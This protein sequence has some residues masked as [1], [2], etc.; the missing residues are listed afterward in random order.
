MNYSKILFLVLLLI[1]NEF[2]ITPENLEIYIAFTDC[3]NLDITVPYSLMTLNRNVDL[4]KRS[5]NG[6]YFKQESLMKQNSEF[7]YKFG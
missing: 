3:C 4:Q 7:M 5:S 2:C 6:A 1:S